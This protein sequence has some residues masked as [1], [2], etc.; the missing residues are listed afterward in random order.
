MREYRGR[1]RVFTNC[2]AFIVALYHI[3]YT[4]GLLTFFD[5]DIGGRHTGIS[6]RLCRCSR[7]HILAR[8]AKIP[9]GSIAL[10]RCGAVRVCASSFML[11]MR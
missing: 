6:N 4:S 3:V 8:D 11:L 1:M 9:Q 7:L 5:I 2:F 10:V